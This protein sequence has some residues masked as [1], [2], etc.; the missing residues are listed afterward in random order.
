MNEAK[1]LAGRAAADRVESGMVVGLGTGSTARHAIIRLGERLAA[2]E[3]ADV[4]G[5][6]TSFESSVLAREHGV[7]L[8]L[9]DQID[10]IDLAIDGADEVDPDLDLIK[11]G[12]GAHTRE[13]IV[14]AN[15]DRFMV[16]V[17]E[18]KLVD[19]LGS[20][21]PVPV[22]VLPMA[23]AV[24]E[25]ALAQLGGV[26]ELRMAQR[27]AGPVVSDQGNL[28]LDCRFSS[29]GLIDDPGE[30]EKTINNIPGVLDNGIF[31]RLA[32][33]VLI[34][35]VAGGEPVVRELPAKDSP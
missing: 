1:R 29:P 31:A 6:P 24:V 35:S 17:D 22:E 10:R 4:A 11:G 34:G 23:V 15:A 18:S 28:I 32:D 14:A 12:G 3:I 5:I 13:K 25:R 16:V 30:L 33:V 20:K 2:G 26:V 7:P 27:K 19:Q 8:A 9:L 21:V